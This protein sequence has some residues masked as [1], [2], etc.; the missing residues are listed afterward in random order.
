MRR[1]EAQVDSKVVGPNSCSPSELLSILLAPFQGWAEGPKYLIIHA[2]D[3]GMCH[4]VN[5]AIIQAFEVEAIS[6]ASLM[7]PC[8]HFE[9]AASYAR[10]NPEKDIGIHLTLT[11]EWNDYRW[12]PVAPLKDV[13]SLTDKDGCF[14]ADPE[15]VAETAKEDEVELELICQIQRA[16]SLGVK[17]THLD[18]HMLTFFQSQPLYSVYAS[19]AE[20]YGIP[21]LGTAS[22]RF[23]G[24][25]YARHI[26]VNTLL[27]AE[28]ETSPNDWS[29]VYLRSMTQLGHGSSVM[30]VHPGFD[31]DELVAI[32]GRVTPFGSAWRQRDLDLLMSGGFKEALGRNHITVVRWQDLQRIRDRAR[33]T[34]FANRR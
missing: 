26:L 7:V 24:Q 4:S 28:A 19:V 14:W 13:S 18:S 8:P 23:A 3:F 20:K 17:P 10:S 11:S 30:L 12:G 2:D 29:S 9:E 32:A 22:E 15:S 16:I 5:R 33:E 31:E 1:D 25:R 34:A 21:F 6:S 27:V